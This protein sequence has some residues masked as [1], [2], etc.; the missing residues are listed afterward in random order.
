MRVGM[1]IIV[2]VLVSMGLVACGQK[3]PLMLPADQTDK[4]AKAIYLI[5]PRKASGEVE[6]S[7]QNPVPAKPVPEH[8]ASIN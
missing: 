5:K 7:L 3:G 4:Q 1:T 6:Q 2:S 8:P